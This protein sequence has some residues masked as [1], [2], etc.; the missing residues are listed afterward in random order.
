MF[1]NCINYTDCTEAQIF[2]LFNNYFPM[3]SYFQ[4]PSIDGVGG[5]W[6]LSLRKTELAYIYYT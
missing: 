5:R 3:V 2:T 6:R 4:W 1:N